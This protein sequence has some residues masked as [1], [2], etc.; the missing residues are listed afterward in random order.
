M[1]RLPSVQ[2]PLFT[3]PLMAFIDENCLVFDSEEENKFEYTAVRTRPVSLGW[4]AC[5]F[6]D[7][8]LRRCRCTRG[9]R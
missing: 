2:G 8:V 1:T 5:A 3:V 4:A 7:R 9:S 6:A